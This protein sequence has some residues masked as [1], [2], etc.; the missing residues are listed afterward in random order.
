MSKAFFLALAG[1]MHENHHRGA[2]GCVPV[3]GIQQEESIELLFLLTFGVLEV[4][5]DLDRTGMTCKPCTSCTAGLTTAS[6]EMGAT[7]EVDTIILLLRNPRQ[8]TL[9]AMRRCRVSKYSTTVYCST[10]QLT[11]LRIIA[12]VYS[13]FCQM[14]MYRKGGEG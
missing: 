12:H 4:K 10:G 9:E 1:S 5:Y 13:L 3:I 11:Q 8:E 14:C 2:H 6:T 7:V